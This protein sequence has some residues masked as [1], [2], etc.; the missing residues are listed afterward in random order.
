MDRHIES[1][2]ADMVGKVLWEKEI[3]ET[4]SPILL[5]ELGQKLVKKICINTGEI[6]HRCQFC[7]CC[8]DIN[9]WNKVVWVRIE[10]I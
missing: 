9:S 2:I 1:E 7:C 4:A 6:C 3:Q 8:V 10:L 5:V